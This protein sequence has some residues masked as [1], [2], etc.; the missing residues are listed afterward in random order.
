M[1]E[2]ITLT[3]LE[4]CNCGS[5]PSQVTLKRCC[6]WNSHKSYFDWV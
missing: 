5:I 1:A 3:P 6:H 4:L 2:E